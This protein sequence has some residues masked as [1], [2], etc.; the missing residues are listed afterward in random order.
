M[1]CMSA[2]RIYTISFTAKR[3]AGMSNSSKVFDL[4][5]SVRKQLKMNQFYSIKHYQ[6]QGPQ[7]FTCR[8]T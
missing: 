3:Q 7:K 2:S 6:F 1:I 8:V 5:N 4:F